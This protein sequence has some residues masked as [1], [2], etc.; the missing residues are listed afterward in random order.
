M[1]EK[2]RRRRINWSRWQKR[3]KKRGSTRRKEAA[4]CEASSVDQLPL[5]PTSAR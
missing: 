5:S 4:R 1:E 3:K 2:E